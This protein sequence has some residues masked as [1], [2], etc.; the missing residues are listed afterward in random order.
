M[1]CTCS[2]PNTSCRNAKEKATGYYCSINLPT[3][4]QTALGTLRHGQQFS[5]LNTEWLINTVFMV[6]PDYVIYERPDGWKLRADLDRV[7]NVVVK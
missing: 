6:Y 7:V 1:T 3:T 4:Q 2:T 5:F